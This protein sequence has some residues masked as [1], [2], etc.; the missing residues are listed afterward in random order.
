MHF[1]CILKKKKASTVTNT[2][3]TTTTTRTSD[4]DKSPLF[5]S[6][7]TCDPR[8]NGAWKWRGEGANGKSFYATDVS[9]YI[10]EGSPDLCEVGLKDDKYNI[11]DDKYNLE[12]GQLQG[13]TYQ[14]CMDACEEAEECMAFSWPVLFIAFFLTRTNDHPFLSRRAPSWAPCTVMPSGG[15]GVYI[16]HQFWG[17]LLTLLCADMRILLMDRCAF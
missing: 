8:L 2:K 9:W 13:K 15:I 12:G 14:Q 1:Y 11:V 7:S 16:T 5:L 4:A 3:T 10:D 17:L 6:G